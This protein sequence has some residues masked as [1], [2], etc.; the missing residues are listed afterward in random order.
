MF[1]STSAAKLATERSDS[2][3]TPAMCRQFYQHS[4]DYSYTHNMVDTRTHSDVE[5]YDNGHNMSVRFG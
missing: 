1:R 5:I 2:T 4:I 3:L